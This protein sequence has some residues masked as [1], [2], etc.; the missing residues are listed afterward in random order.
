M[1]M[2]ICVMLQQQG[3]FPQSWCWNDCA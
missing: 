1:T 2:R 3:R